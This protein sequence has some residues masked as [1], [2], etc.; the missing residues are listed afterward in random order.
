MDAT[1]Q[2]EEEKKGHEKI[3]ELILD[4]DEVTWQSILYDLI[5]S[6][7]MNP[8][9]VNVSILTQKYIERIKLL[10]EHDFRISGKI[11]LAASLLLKIKSNRWMKEDIA[12]LDNLFMSAEE[13]DMNS[14]LEDLE[15]SFQPREQVDAHLIPRTPQPRKRKVSIYD[16]VAA[17]EKAL[18]V[19]HRR[20]LRDIPLLDIRPPVKKKDISE[21]IKEIYQKV[22]LFFKNKEKDRLTFSMLAPSQRREDKIYTFIPLLHLSNQRKI[23]IEQYQSFGEIEIMLRDKKEVE[24]QLNPQIQESA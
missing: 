11:V 19:K 2:A 4:K 1:V 6:E 16:L 10:Q 21:I 3:L 15:D 17:L 20:V 24:K 22:N 18:E 5:N 8:W 7:Q 13:E 12:N 23:D 9:D 14:L